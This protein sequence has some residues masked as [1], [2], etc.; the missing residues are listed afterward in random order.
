MEEKMR[1]RFLRTVDA[2]NKDKAVFEEYRRGYI[3]PVMGAKFISQNNGC[4]VTP[5]MFVENARVLGYDPNGY[6]Y[7]KF[8][9]RKRNDEYEYTK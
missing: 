2:S 5:E 1:I 4:D 8:V 6:P 3:G 7:V 9:R